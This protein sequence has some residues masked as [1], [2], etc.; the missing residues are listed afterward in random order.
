MPVW[1]VLIVEDD[2][3][4]REFFAAS[5]SHCDR[6]ELAA[7]MGSVAEARAWLANPEH[8]ATKRRP[9]GSAGE[10]VEV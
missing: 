5:V 6:L 7:S 10:A 8:L 9:P 1:R 4:T 3:Q 2:S